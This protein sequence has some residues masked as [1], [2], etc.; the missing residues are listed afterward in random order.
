MALADPTSL[1]EPVAAAT[2]R[3]AAILESLNVTVADA[4]EITATGR[5]ALDAPM[6][7]TGEVHG[8]FA[9]LG[10]LDAILATAGHRAKLG[11]ALTLDWSGDGQLS[12]TVHNGR[13]K[14]AGRNLRHDALR[15]TDVRLSAVYSPQ[16]FA[17]D[18]LLVVAGTLGSTR[19]IDNRL[20][21]KDA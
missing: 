6:A 10:K 2:I 8:A 7:Y 16:Q 3:A 21:S 19:L 9:N 5:V 17:T 1:P 14:I 12:D 18:E 20:F 11:G 13:L 15:L 4:G